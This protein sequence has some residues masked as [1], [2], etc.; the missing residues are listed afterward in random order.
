M[1]T[2]KASSINDAWEKLLKDI[3]KHGYMPDDI[4]FYKAER[5]IVEI[6]KPKVEVPHKL[7]PRTKEEL[8]IINEYLCTGKNEENVWH[9]WTK[10][11]YHRLF[12]SPN[13]QIEYIINKLKERPGG[14]ACACTWRKEIDQI[15]ERMPCMLVIWCQSREG[16]I[17][18]HV[19]GQE[20][21][22]YKK[23]IMNM[24]EYVAL[25]KHLAKI[26]NLEIGRFVFSLD[27]G[28]IFMKDKDSVLNLVNML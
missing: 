7:F 10:I 4:E 5:I 18:L 12:D 25:Q 20:G 8:D 17:D 28:Y 11:Y 2:L 19:H 24:Q 26:L 14:K 21:D 23:S 9:E 16:K 6:D 13:S 27:F 1:I 22:V 15:A 3:I